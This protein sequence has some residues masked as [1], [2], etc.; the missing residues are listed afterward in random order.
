MQFNDFRVHCSLILD[1]F[2]PVGWIFPFSSISHSGSVYKY[3]NN[4]NNEKKWRHFGGQNGLR[5]FFEYVGANCKT[6]QAFR[7]A[8]V[9]CNWNWYFMIMDSFCIWP[10]HFRIMLDYRQT[11][12][13][14]SIFSII[15]LPLTANHTP[16]NP[17]IPIAVL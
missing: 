11:I 3:I 5:P 9:P 8:I 13:E 7:I 10:E 16:S 4:N 14:I 6:I 1:E 17:T 15:E 2:L 12:I